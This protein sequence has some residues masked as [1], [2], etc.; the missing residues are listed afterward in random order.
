MGKRPN[1]F[2]TIVPYSPRWAEQFED[3]RR[4]LQ[5]AVGDVAISI[6]HVGSTAVP[7]LSAKPTID[8]LMVVGS[9]RDIVDRVDALIALGYD[10]RQ[11][12]EFVGSETHLFLR[13]V[14]HRGDRTHHLHVVQSGEQEIE[15]YRRFRD[16]LRSDPKLLSQYE[17]LKIELAARHADD[18]MRYVTEK[19]DW[20][21]EIVAALRTS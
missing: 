17:T 10:F 21:D 15:D 9:P 7:G 6:E 19:S 4:A 12:N 2:V 1:A 18:R 16:A 3:E 5:T 14:D 8:I 11:H 13:K 20:V